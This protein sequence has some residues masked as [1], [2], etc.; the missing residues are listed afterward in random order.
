MMTP[1]VAILAREVTTQC[2]LPPGSVW[3]RAHNPDS[4]EARSIA[5]TLTGYTPTQILEAFNIW[6]RTHTGTGQGPQPA[7]LAE[8][9]RRSQPEGVLANPRDCPHPAPHGFD[10]NP[11]GTRTA[12]CRYCHS[13]WAAPY[14][15]TPIEE[16]E[17][18]R[19]RG[20]PV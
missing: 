14:I 2:L 15:K 7:E 17:I 5:K 9:A 6:H 13:E 1:D 11:D 12:F 4:Y 3:G 19:T 8:L 18:R 16:A 20:V 10:I